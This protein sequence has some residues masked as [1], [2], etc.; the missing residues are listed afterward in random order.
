MRGVVRVALGDESTSSSTSWA[1][2]VER[3]VPTAALVGVVGRL[4][5]VDRRR[6]RVL[7]RVS[8]WGGLRVE[9]LL[10]EALGGAALLESVWRLEALEAAG[11]EWVALAGCPWPTV[12]EGLFLGG[13]PC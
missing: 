5:E 2:R 8:C 7:D 4:G 9:D 10:A 6:L 12:D 3:R 11:V 13:L 1:R